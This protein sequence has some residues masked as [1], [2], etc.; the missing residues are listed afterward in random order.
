MVERA[1]IQQRKPKEL[2]RL[3]GVR[4]DTFEAMLNAL[5]NQIRSECYRNRRKRFRLRFNLLAVVCN[6]QLV[7]SA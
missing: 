5:S 4:R 1:Q 6:H 3:T 7:S 2:L